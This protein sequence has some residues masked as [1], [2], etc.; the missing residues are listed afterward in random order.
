MSM[1]NC[2]GEKYNFQKLEVIH[3]FVNIHRV[4]MYFHVLGKSSGRLSIKLFIVVIPKDWKKVL[5]ELFYKILCCY[6]F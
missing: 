4:S 1:L 2:W 5:R 3:F 6:N